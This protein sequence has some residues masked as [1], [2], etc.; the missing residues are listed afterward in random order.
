MRILIAN[1]G[2]SSVKLRLLDADGL[3]AAAADLPAD[4][5]GF[6]ADDL[7]ETLTRWP[8]PDAIGHRIVHGGRQF[9]GPVR[10]DPAVRAQLDALV[11]LAPLHQ[12]KSLAALD[13]L[14]RRYPG[15][16]A[17]AS[18][19][20]AFHATMPPR[21]SVYPVPAEWRTRY[22]IRR[23]GFHGLSHAYCCRRTAELLDA[24]PERIRI[25][26][27][28]L[29]AGASITATVGCRSV[30]TSMGFTPLDGLVMATRA[31]SVDPGLILWLEEHEQLRP[32][33]I[34]DVLEKRSGLLALGGSADVRVLERQA[35]AGDPDATLAIDVFS[36][37]AASWIGAMAVASRGVDAVA[38]TGG[39]GENSASIRAR[40]V[41]HLDHLGLALD[42]LLNTTGRGDREIGAAGSGARVVVV[43]AREDLQIATEVRSV[44]G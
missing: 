31:G 27:C 2:S 19:D 12:P 38:F 3:V 7:A 9:T 29:G 25:I 44:L 21:A 37:R 4:A 10:I 13:E 28:H 11:E 35:A 26:S 34:A 8:E 5:G 42:D 40:V 20:T 33:E 6:A 39:I 16:P 23:Y 30:D 41:A 36:Y 32:A 1:A 22:G 15:I 43:A 24:P 17:V 14:T 18:F